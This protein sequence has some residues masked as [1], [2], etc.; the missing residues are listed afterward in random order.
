MTIT[1]NK[2][3]NL[4]SLTQRKANTSNEAE[5]LKEAKEVETQPLGGIE[6]RQLSDWVLRVSG[7]LDTH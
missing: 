6:G 1:S 3:A 2:T 5:S 7:W 4:K